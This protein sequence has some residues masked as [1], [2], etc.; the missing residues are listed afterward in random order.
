MKNKIKQGRAFR[1]F[2]IYF[3]FCDKMPTYVLPTVTVECTDGRMKKRKNGRMSYMLPIKDSNT[4]LCYSKH[5]K[6][7]YERRLALNSWPL[8]SNIA[9]ALYTKDSI[10]NNRSPIYCFTKIIRWYIYIY[11]YIYICIYIYTYIYI[12]TIQS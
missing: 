7:K 8:D 1:I 12:C 6:M 10:E 2:R 11:I 4:N 5:A 3:P 9:L